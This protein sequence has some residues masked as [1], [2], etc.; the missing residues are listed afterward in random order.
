MN[1]TFVTF[2]IFTLKGNALPAAHLLRHSAF[3]QAY[4]L[5]NVKYDLHA[6]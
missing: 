6:D 4:E 1:Q 5:E 2:K 3:V